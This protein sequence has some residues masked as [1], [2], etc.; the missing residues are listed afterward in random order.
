MSPFYVLE[1]QLEFRVGDRTIVAG[2]GTFLFAPK[3]IPHTFK[4]VG[5]TPARFLTIISPAGLE[6]FFAERNNLQKEMSPNDPAYVEKHKALADRYGMEF[7]SDWSFP[8]D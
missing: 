7:R 2:P 3:G 5:S 6:N 8:P 1:G 4:S